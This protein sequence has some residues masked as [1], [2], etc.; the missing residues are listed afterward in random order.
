MSLKDPKNSINKL[1]QKAEKAAQ[2]AAEK[3]QGKGKDGK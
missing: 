1:T 2:K 3:I